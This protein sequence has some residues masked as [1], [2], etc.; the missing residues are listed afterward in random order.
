MLLKCDFQAV[1]VSSNSTW[2]PSPSCLDTAHLIMGFDIAVRKQYQIILESS[3]SENKVTKMFGRRMKLRC[4]TVC[5]REQR[6]WLLILQKCLVCG[7]L[8]SEVWMSLIWNNLHESVP[9]LLCVSC[10]M[11]SEP[12]KNHCVFW[13]FRHPPDEWKT[14]IKVPTLNQAKQLRMGICTPVP[15]F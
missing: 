7:L 3:Q 2:D 5:E 4:G 11:V 15:T 14:W 13:W 10:L 9:F 12:E 6:T 1:P 8:G